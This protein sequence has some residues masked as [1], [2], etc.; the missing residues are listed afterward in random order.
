MRPHT[1]HPH[2]H[3]QSVIGITH[4]QQ[5]CIQEC[6]P[7]KKNYICSLE[8]SLASL[9]DKFLPPGRGHGR[10]D[11][12]RT[13]RVLWTPPPSARKAKPCRPQ[14]QPKRS[15]V[16]LWVLQDPRQKGRKKS[17]TG[18]RPG[19]DR[20]RRRERSG[21]GAARGGPRGGEVGRDRDPG[22]LELA[23]REKP[24]A[25]IRAPR[26]GEPAVR[27][28]AAPGRGIRGAV[29]NAAGCWRVMSA[30]GPGGAEDRWTRGW[31]PRLDRAPGTGSG[32]PE[33]RK[34]HCGAR[35]V[36]GA[37]DEGGSRAPLPLGPT[38][39]GW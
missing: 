10:Q 36:P 7:S 27:R 11:G 8:A 17:D 39:G 25:V 24:G 9:G 22:L 12:G 32:L 31:A 28:R 29:P 26:G 35:P 33:H 1:Q 2:S 19:G 15:L 3:L 4:L 23:P 30:T 37:T 18:R 14:R 38:A 13:L 6:A 21:V 34:R 20:A 5:H 16:G